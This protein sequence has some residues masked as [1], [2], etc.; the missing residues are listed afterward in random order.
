VTRRGNGEGSIGQLK[1]GRWLARTYFDGR[2]KAYYGKTR[3]EVAKK[4]AIGIKA[5]T[6][7]LPVPSDKQTFAQFVEKWVEAITP[8]V[9]PR[10]AYNY[11]LLLRHH[12]VPV[13]GRMPLTKIQPSDIV[14]VYEQRRKAGAAPMSILHLHRALFRAFRFAERWGDVARNVVALVDAPKVT[15]AEMRCLNADE[16]RTLLATAQGDRLEALLVLALSTGMRSGE[17]L[18]LTWRSVD[19]D[20][21]SI[22]V[23]A[24][25]QPTPSG[26]ALMEV[27]TRRSRRVI[28]VEPRVVA[29][30]RRHRAAQ[31]MERRVAG[32]VW[33]APVPD[34]VFATSIGRPI[35][36]RELIRKWFRPLLKKA[37]LPPIRIHDL[38]HS[39]ASIALARGVHPKVVQE[40]LGHSTIA[41]TLDLYSHVVPS[42]QREAAK[43]MGAALFG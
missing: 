26:L 34:L 37:G 40:A 14:H 28:D 1:N 20:R 29:S 33:D 5:H 43:E 9:R 8:T 25:L 23:I 31:E 2:R 21:G 19:V 32:D 24:S 27:K 42:L 13:L 3:A 39:Y 6:D 17:L 12:A 30:L 10:T 4:L 7:G 22:S 11:A 36:G 18:G 35:D 41:V 16:A 38:R 15:R